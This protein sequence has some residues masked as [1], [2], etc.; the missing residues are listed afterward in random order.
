MCN[1]FI[2][3][4]ICVHRHDIAAIILR[5]AL[6][7]NQSINQSINNLCSYFVILFLCEDNQKDKNG[8][9]LTLIDNKSYQRYQRGYQQPLIE[10]AQTEIKRI[11][12]NTI[13]N[14]TFDRNL[15]IKQYEH[16]VKPERS[17][18]SLFAQVKGQNI[19]CNKNIA[20]LPF[21]I[22]KIRNNQ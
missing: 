4:I 17:L 21:G 16:H 9:S 5:Q 13:V 3:Y 11:K 12:R 10:D 22:S 6:N 18:S 2:T 15:H 7:T 20:T 14:K 19:Q 8:I 1:G